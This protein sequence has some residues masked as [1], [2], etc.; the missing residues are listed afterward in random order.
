MLARTVRRSA[1]HAPLKRALSSRASA[2]LSALDLPVG[3]ATELPGVYDGAW[4]GSGEVFESKCPTTGEVLARVK[5]VRVHVE[6]QAWGDAHTAA[7]RPLP[8]SCA[9]R[10]TRPAKHTLSSGRSRRRAEERSCVK[11]A[12]RSLPRYVLC[13]VLSREKN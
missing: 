12:R 13:H 1:T 5:S 9:L 4:T 2:V 3:D 11:S 6:G 10:S 7:Y 8:R